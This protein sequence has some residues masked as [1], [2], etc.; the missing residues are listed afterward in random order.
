MEENL[1]MMRGGGWERYHNIAQESPLRKYECSLTSAVLA[2]A[3]E[4]ARGHANLLE[5]WRKRRG[6]EPTAAIYNLQ[7]TELSKDNKDTKDLMGQDCADLCRYCI[8]A[9]VASCSQSF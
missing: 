1:I 5:N 2:R 8:S 7:L 3:A 4:T 9:T 6:V